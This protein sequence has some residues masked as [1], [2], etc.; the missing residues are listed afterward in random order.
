MTKIIPIIYS[1]HN[2]K[3][4][5]GHIILRALKGFRRHKAMTDDSTYNIP[6]SLADMRNYISEIGARYS[7]EV[8][9][10]LLRARPS[11]SATMSLSRF[12]VRL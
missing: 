12:F 9:Q 11:Y 8:C 3:Y 1:Q 10:G 2:I 4:S 5:L 6:V 7:N